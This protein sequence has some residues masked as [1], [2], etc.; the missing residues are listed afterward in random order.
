MSDKTAPR[1]TATGGGGADHERKFQSLL[2]GL[3][4]EY[5]LFTHAP[6]G[7]VTYVSPSVRDI[8]GVDPEMMVGM[9]WRDYVRENNFGREE[10]ERVDDEV[11]QGKLFHKLVVEINH[12]DGTHKLFEVQ[13][14]PVFDNTGTYVSMEG[15]AKDITESVRVQNELQTLRD[16]LEQRVVQ[17]T[18]I[19]EQTNKKLR[20]SESRY[21]DLVEKQGELI[22]RWGPDGRRRDVND[23]YCRYLGQSR[24]ELIDQPFLPAIVEEDRTVFEEAFAAIS[25]QRP[26]VTYEHRVQRADGSIR[27]VQWTDTAFYNDHGMPLEYLSVGRDV[28]ELKRA[29]DRLR[30]QEN[31]L[32][33][34]SRLA[35][36]GE[37]V[38]GIAHEIHQPLHAASTFAEAARRHLEAGD[39]DA[40]EAA[41]ECTKEIA[42]AISRT[43]QIIRRLRNFT[44]PQSEQM[45]TLDVNAVVSE[46]VEIMAFA[47]RRADVSLQTELATVLPPVRGDRIQL[48]Q[49]CVNLIQ[50][51]CDACADLP[52]N[53][54]RLVVQTLAR[55]NT[56]LVT[57]R[58]SGRGIAADNAD[59]LF[60]AF[61]TTKSGGMGMGLSLS[62][63]IAESH[64]AKLTARSNADGPG[65]TL[66]L[67]L[68]ACKALP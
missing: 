37:L 14:R 36:M 48:Q 50:N 1:M 33:H 64:G 7:T 39:A 11:A 66:E 12:L 18:K 15:I 16:D 67:A 59:H 46:A 31:H 35:T 19:L 9:N 68:P 55:Q 44:R 10:A 58:D 27:W 6:D 25:P 32:A 38:A 20:E 54:R 56:V 8:L 21:R 30:E 51:A 61:F 57:F 62:R 45:E 5:I 63:S 23:A 53:Q 49:I 24:K 65:A 52:A 28:T 17:R 3:R 43:A 2:E 41:I 60:D 26:T 13:E 29:Q 22:V 4:G 42:D 47:M 40:V 34:L